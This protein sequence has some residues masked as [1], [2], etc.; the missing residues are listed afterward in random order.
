MDFISAYTFRKYTNIQLYEIHP[1]ELELF[2]ASGQTDAS[3]LI[4][5]VRKFE[6][7]A[8][9]IGKLKCSGRYGMHFLQKCQR[10]G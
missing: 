4:A 7:V 9:M 1:V 8:K 10:F 5:A 2:H 6:K 3:K